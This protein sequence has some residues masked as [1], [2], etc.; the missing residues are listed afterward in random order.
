MGGIIN[1]YLNTSAY[2]GVGA[3]STPS[4]I[5]GFPGMISNFLVYSKTLSP[6]EVLQNYNSI[7][8]RFNI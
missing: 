1:S 2:V 5:W 8:S 3:Y 6:T 7:K 4:R